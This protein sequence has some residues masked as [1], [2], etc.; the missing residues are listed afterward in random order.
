MNKNT[1]MG[2]LICAL[3]ALLSIQISNY[4]GIELLNLEKSPISPIIIT[5][6]TRPELVIIVGPSNG[7]CVMCA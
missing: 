2:I 4:I 5:I 3:T 7:F 6:G 1:I